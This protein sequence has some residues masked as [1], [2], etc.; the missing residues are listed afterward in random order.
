MKGTNCTFD[1]VTDTMEFIYPEND[2]HAIITGIFFTIFGI[3][4]LIV[5]AKLFFDINLENL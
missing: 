2:T 3:F 1:I 4:N 5:S